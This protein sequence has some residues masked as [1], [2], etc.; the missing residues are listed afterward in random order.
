[1]SAQIG[2]RTLVILPNIGI[3]VDGALGSMG[4]SGS[5]IHLDSKSN[6]DQPSG[7]LRDDQRGRIRAHRANLVLHPPVG[8]KP[9]SP[10]PRGGHPRAAG[11]GMDQSMHTSG[12]VGLAHPP[13]FTTPVGE[14]REVEQRTLAHHDSWVT[15]IMVRDHGIGI[16][17]E[18]IPVFVTRF[19]RLVKSGDEPLS[20]NGTW[21]LSVP[22]NCTSARGRHRG[23]L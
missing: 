11:S 15:T 10:E 2:S 7:D 5:P 22:R 18:Q 6:V 14:V 9:R 1:M 12:V 20:R 4:A 3:V 17:A 21:A 8:P 16:G 13:G 23:R 19:G